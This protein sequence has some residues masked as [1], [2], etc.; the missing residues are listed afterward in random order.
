MTTRQGSLNPKPTIKRGPSN[1]SNLL[2]ITRIRCDRNR[3]IQ[4]EPTFPQ[5]KYVES[6]L[7][8]TAVRK[9]HSLHVSTSVKMETNVLN[10]RW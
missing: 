5:V 8:L 1:V 2:V 3:R 7:F 10:S 9:S 4:T 6:A